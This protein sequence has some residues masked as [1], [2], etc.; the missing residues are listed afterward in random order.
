MPLRSSLLLALFLGVGCDA[1]PAA[2]PPNE[3]P[4]ADAG[5]DRSVELRQEVSIDG[6]ASADPEGAELTFAWSASP[7]NPAP[8]IFPKTQASFSF[9][10]T[11]SGIYWFILT[12][13]DGEVTSPPDTVKI[14]VSSDGNRPP[15]A[16]AGPDLIIP[17]DAVIPLSAINSYD[18]DGDLLSYLWQI[19]QSPGPAEIADSSAQQTTVQLSA[20]GDYSFRL[21]VDDGRASSDDDVII[22][23]SSSANLSPTAA[24]GPDQQVAV[25]TLVTL[26]GS[27]SADPEGDELTFRWTL[28]RTPG[29]VVEL[30]DSTLVQPTFTPPETGEYV[31]GLTVSD[32]VNASIQDVVTILVL[33]EIFTEQEGMIEIPAGPFNMGSDQGSSDERPVH[34]VDL[35]T[36]WIDKFEVTVSGYQACVDGGFCD[37]AGN[38]AG[39]NAARSDRPDHPINCITWEQAQNFCIWADKLLPTEA[40]WEKAARGID[41]RRFVWGDRFPHPD[42]LNYGD[43]IG[44]TT[45]VGT[46]PAGLSFYGVHNMGGNVNEWTTDYYDANY[47]VDSPELDPPGPASG[48]LRVVRG[49]N[50]KVGFPTEALTATV[51]Q[52]FVPTTQDNSLGFRCARRQPPGE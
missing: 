29:S 44:S 36:F 8:V 7:A 24:A 48:S 51:R 35:S 32:S 52:A 45:P 30:S 13:D 23:I 41:S 25:G 33:N 20:S 40:E 11:I 50:W 16:D 14:T 6:S 27:A 46:Y 12:V 43:N 5:S 47:Y 9:V 39:C 31:F 2:P 17:A 38:A 37:P 21:T 42:L 19:V 18:P 3:I 10:P 28:G 4:L 15:V 1:P 49:T 22:T 34:R 26:D